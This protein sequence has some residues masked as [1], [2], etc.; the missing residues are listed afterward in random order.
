VIAAVHHHLFVP[1][2]A[3]DASLA[4]LDALQQD[5]ARPR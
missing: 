5:A 3:A 2:E 1:L 4:V